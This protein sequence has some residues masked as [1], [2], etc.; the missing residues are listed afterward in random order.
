MKEVNEPNNVDILL[1]K[2]EDIVVKVEKLKEI[3]HSKAIKPK[4]IERGPLFARVLID[5]HV[6]LLSHLEKDN[7]SYVSW[8]ENQ[9]GKL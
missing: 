7:I 8:L 2:I 6:K 1:A 5:L 9:I 4:K 3:K